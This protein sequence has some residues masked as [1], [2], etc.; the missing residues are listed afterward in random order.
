MGPGMLHQQALERVRLGA[1]RTREGLVLDVR[2]H[3]QTQPS[4]LGKGL[5]ADLARKWPLPRMGPVMLHEGAPRVEALR[6]ELASLGLA[7]LTLRAVALL[8]SAV[9]MYG[10]QVGR[11]RVLHREGPATHVTDKGLF[12]S[13]EPP[14]GDQP[15]RLGKPLA[16]DF[17]AVGLCP[18]VDSLMGLD[19]ALQPE[20]L[21]TNGAR[22]RPLP[23]MGP[24]VVFQAVP[25][26]KPS[27]AHVACVRLLT[28]MSACVV[29]ERRRRRKVDPALCAR[30][31]GPGRAPAMR[32]GVQT[33]PG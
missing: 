13:V 30:Q 26:C 15:T 28:R 29:A 32:S 1:L 21:A 7:R 24:C 20:A 8:P 5:R 17:T 27:T 10:P 4:A 16:T 25:T 19:C 2:E 18:C 12:P 9:T 14:M 31:R 22:I 3:V 11:E 6:A 33:Q 23:R